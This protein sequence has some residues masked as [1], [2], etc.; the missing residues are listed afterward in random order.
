MF[1]LIAEAWV[2]IGASWRMLTFQNGWEKGYD[3]SI[4][5]FWRSFLGILAAAPLIGLT[6]VFR[7]AEGS[8]IGWF[9]EYFLQGL[10]WIAF[11]FAASLACLVTGAR[12]SFVRWVVVHNWA[13]FWLYF[14]IFLVWMLYTSGLLPAAGAG[15]ALFVYTYVRVLAHWRIAYVSLGLPTITAA[16]AAAVPILAIDVVIAVYL[17]SG[18]V[19][20]ATG[21]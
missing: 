10:A 4:G 18:A 20:E 3:V 21:G 16:L 17:A 6:H 19:P 7:A 5:G 14:Y 15:I 2:A 8:S 11:P 12:R 13:V 1:R 9:D